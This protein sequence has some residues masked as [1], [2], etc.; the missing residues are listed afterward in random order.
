MLAEKLPP[1][2]VYFFD[3]VSR[4]ALELAHASAKRGAVIVFEPSGVKD[5]GLF[6]EAIRI[7]HIV[8]YSHERLG[9]LGDFTRECRPFI[10]IQTLGEKGLRY[11]LNGSIWPPAGWREM[12]AFK[13]SRLR[14]SVGAGDWCT[15][16]ML[17]V[18]AQKGI[19]GLRRSSL[20]RIESAIALGQGLAAL[21][22]NYE[23]AR[24]IMYALTKRRIQ[25]KIN[26]LLAGA[27]QHSVEDKEDTDPKVEAQ[28]SSVCPNCANSEL[29]SARSHPGR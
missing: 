13:V 29:G 15:G 10:E 8:K 2:N 11:R 12:K 28:L 9:S 18:L 5:R 24:G 23:G 27:K 1:A 21:S 20:S 6:K 25:S 7:S 19:A 3:R 16:G 14:D 4:G 22:C 26:E 17:H